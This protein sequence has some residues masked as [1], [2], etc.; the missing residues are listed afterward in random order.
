MVGVLLT[1]FHGRAAP[2]PT[3]KEKL[4]ECLEDADYE[5]LLRTVQVGLSPIDFRH[6]VAIVGAG[7]AGLTAAKLLND[8]GHQ[9]RTSCSFC[10]FMNFTFACGDIFVL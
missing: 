7:M 10:T 6:H 8:A 3:L 9:V 1:L 4:A 5:E 2:D